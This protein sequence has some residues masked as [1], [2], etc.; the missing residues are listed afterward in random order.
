[1]RNR[2]RS[3]QSGSNSDSIELRHPIGCLPETID[4]SLKSNS[5]GG[6]GHRSPRVRSA[7]SSAIKTVG[8]FG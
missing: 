7:A 1:M 3:R 5:G 2:H 8:A 4:S 6:K